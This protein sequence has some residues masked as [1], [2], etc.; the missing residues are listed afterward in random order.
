MRSVSQPAARHGTVLLAM[1]V[2]TFGEIR[3]SAASFELSFALAPAESQGRYQGVFSM[4]SGVGRV[5]SQSLATLLCLDVGFAGW[6]LLG[7]LILA[8]GLAA[9]PTTSWALRTGPSVL[10]EEAEQLPASAR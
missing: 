7:A 10:P 4:G 2:H 8:A 3:Y 9:V 5:V 6:V 1:V